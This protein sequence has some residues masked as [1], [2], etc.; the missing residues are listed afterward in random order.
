MEYSL[1]EIWATSGNSLESFEEAIKALDEKTEVT[2]VNGGDILLYYICSP[3]TEGR[4]MYKSIKIDGEYVDEMFSA[5][6]AGVPNGVVPKPELGIITEKYIST[7]LANETIKNVGFLLSYY[8]NGKQRISYMSDQAFS[9]LLQR[10]RLGGE[11]LRDRHVLPTVGETCGNISFYGLCT[12]VEQLQKTN[13]PITLVERKEKNKE[14]GKAERKCFAALSGKYQPVPMTTL[15]NVIKNMMEGKEGLG[16]AVVRSWYLDQNVAEIHLEFP[17]VA[18]ELSAT[19]KLKDTMIPGVVLRTSDTGAASIGGYGTWRLPDRR[20]AMRSAIDLDAMVVSEEFH[21]RHIGDVTEEM[22][23]QECDKEIFAQI[24]NLPEALAGKF[25]RVIGNGDVS[26]EEGR[27]KNLEDV[28]ASIRQ[29]FMDLKLTK[30]VSEKGSR[31]GDKRSK[32]ILEALL[33]EIDPG[34]V[35]TQYDLA[36][37]IMNIPGRTEGL[38]REMKFRLAKAC[39]QAPFIKIGVPKKDP[40]FLMPEE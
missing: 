17:E 4:K 32:A 31:I 13:Q 26:T 22:V 34:I 1:R 3:A 20:Y 15:T 30:Q 16:E 12:M 29:A 8:V 36:V 9:M 2:V 40:I 38:S 35:Y 37:M 10:V 18:K 23:I 19:Y 21:R 28:K 5:L 6:C 11:A 24:R 27:R 33:E 14:N 7:E 25:G 39:G